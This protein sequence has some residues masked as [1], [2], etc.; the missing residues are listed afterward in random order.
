MGKSYG[1]PNSPA[2]GAG[3]ALIGKVGIDQTTDGTTNK[4]NVN[5]AT[6]DNLNLNANIQVANTDN[7]SSNPLHVLD[8]TAVG[9]LGGKYIATTDA[10]TPAEGYV[11]NAIQVITDCS[12]TLAGAPSGITTVSL[13]AGM[14]IY[15]RYTSC[16]LASG[17]VIAYNG[18]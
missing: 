6:H 18:K 15:G 17:S 13:T 5:Q 8:N 11:F 10:T 16:T 12:I 14:I 2:I 9:N 3:T 1:S 4:V 7:S